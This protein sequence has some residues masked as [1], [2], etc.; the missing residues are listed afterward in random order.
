V[1]DPAVREALLAR[2]VAALRDDARL[3]GAVLVGSGACGFRDEYSDLDVVAVVGREHDASAVYQDWGPRLEQRL[4]VIYRA[5][6]GPFQLA[7]RLH[8][9]LLDA[10]GHLL[11]LDLSF[12]PIDD[13]CATREHWKV[14]FDRTAGPDDGG[15]VHARMAAPLPE[16]APLSGSLLSFDTACGRVWECHKALRRGRIWQ[17]ALALHELQELTLRIAC[18]GRF[19][20]ARR[21]VSAQRLADDLPPALLAAVAATVVPVERDALAGALRQLAPIMFDEARALYRRAGE[22]FPERLATALLAELA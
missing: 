13:L 5:P 9:A 6:A 7:H 4:P 11:E 21:H 14:L 3:A 19:E 8:V 15:E 20:D 12:A 10:G 17:A 16:L 2:T 18:L 1:V 22:P